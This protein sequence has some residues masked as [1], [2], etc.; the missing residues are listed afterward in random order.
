MTSDNAENMVKGCAQMIANSSA[1]IKSVH[2]RCAAHVVNLIVQAVLNAPGVKK[3]LDK[4]RKFV[5]FI[6][7]SSKQKQNLNAAA[8]DLMEQLV[9]D[10]AVA[11]AIVAGYWCL[12]AAPE[13]GSDRAPTEP[14]DFKVARILIPFLKTF[15]VITTELSGS[16]YPNMQM[17]YQFFVYMKSTV[18]TAVVSDVPIVAEAA[19]A[20][21]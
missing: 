11:A 16:S 19:L 21:E 3:Q 2:V 1:D 20:M 12:P 6:H 14:E 18:A 17:V 8:K 4:L 9:C 13:V 5:S 10:D 15:D 7:N